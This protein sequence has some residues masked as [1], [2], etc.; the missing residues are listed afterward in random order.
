MEHIS[1]HALR[2]EGDGAPHPAGARTQHFYPRPPRGGR[3]SRNSSFGKS[4]VFLSTPSARRATTRGLRRSCRGPISIHALREEGDVQHHANVFDLAISIHALREEGDWDGNNFILTYF[5]FLSTPSARRA[6]YARRRR[7]DG[8]VISIHA[9]REEGDRPG[10]IRHGPAGCISIHALR[11]EGDRCSGQAAGPAADFYPRPPRGG[12]R[13]N[14][15]T[16]ILPLKFLS[17]PSARRATPGLCPDAQAGRISIHALREEGDQKGE[18]ITIPL[19]DFYPRPPRGGRPSASP[20]TA[21]RSGFLSTPSARR[22]TSE[23]PQLALVGA[24]SIHALRE[25]GDVRLS[26]PRICEVD[27]YPRPPRGGRLQSLPCSAQTSYFYPRPPRGGRPR[28]ASS[29]RW[30]P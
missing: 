10:R 22:A 8:Y 14:G 27:F 26:V 1:I 19:N 6:T 20:S 4:K 25:K 2:E 17:T 3:R 24:I 28:P 29:V 21:R 7:A 9:L 11:E 13:L 15:K 16:Q 23:L 30:T 18:P 12:R 5:Q